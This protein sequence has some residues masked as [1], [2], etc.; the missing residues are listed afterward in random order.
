MA[1]AINKQAMLDVLGPPD[2]VMRELERFGEDTRVLST[3]QPALIER[4]AKRWI[5][6]LDGTVVASADTLSTLL[7]DTDH[8][9][10]PRRRLIVRFIDRTPRT[11]IL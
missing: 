8:R 3:R 4:F 5:A 1:A 2:E 7:A 9:G 6:I 10:L 11:M